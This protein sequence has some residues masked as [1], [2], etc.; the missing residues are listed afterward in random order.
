M[1]QEEGK[2]V[3]LKEDEGRRKLED[4]GLIA[5]GRWK[6]KRGLSSKGRTKSERR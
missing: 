1:G 3:G 2:V 4:G 6:T 5:G